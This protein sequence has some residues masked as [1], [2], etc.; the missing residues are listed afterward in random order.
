MAADLS[1]FVARLLHLTAT[2][3]NKIHINH[4]NSYS[5]IQKNFRLPIYEIPT[6]KT[7]YE[8]PTNSWVSKSPVVTVW[9]NDSKFQ[10]P[11]ALFS[12]LAII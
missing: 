6:K 3:C 1:M 4:F 9:Q 11:M 5:T 2:F 12:V 7:K 10:Q 8:K